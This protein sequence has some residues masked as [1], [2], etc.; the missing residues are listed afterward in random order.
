M[1]L[2]C[3]DQGAAACLAVELS[4]ILRFSSVSHR[5]AGCSY[6]LLF[7]LHNRQSLYMALLVYMLDLACTACRFLWGGAAGR[8]LMPALTA[9]P[10]RSMTGENFEE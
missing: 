7:Q 9:T 5:R 3:G 6:A 10:G 2:C 1:Q 8:S 4:M